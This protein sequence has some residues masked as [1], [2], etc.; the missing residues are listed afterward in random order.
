MVLDQATL[1]VGMAIAMLLAALAV[2]QL[3]AYG[4][5]VWLGLPT[6]AVFA[7]ECARVTVLSAVAVALGSYVAAAGWAS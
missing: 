5:F 4:V 6:P 1:L 3:A 2:T 7:H